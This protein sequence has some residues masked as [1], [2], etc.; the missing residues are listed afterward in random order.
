[1]IEDPPRR[2]P[3][4]VR[5]SSHPNR[6]FKLLKGVSISLHPS[7]KAMAQAQR[8]S[9]AEERFDVV[10]LFLIH[11]TTRIGQHH[12]HVPHAMEATLA[13]SLYTRPLVR[14]FVALFTLDITDQRN[15]INIC[16]VRTTYNSQYGGQYR[17]ALVQQAALSVLTSCTSLL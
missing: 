11:A 1:M 7:T 4:G 13:L 2:Y 6:S 14:S 3:A 5:G 15:R 10:Y 17:R 9:R 16:W 12:A 8:N